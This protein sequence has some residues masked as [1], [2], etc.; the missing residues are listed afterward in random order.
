MD[1]ELNEADT[2]AELDEH[3]HLAFLIGEERY[4]IDVR[5]IVEVLRMPRIQPLP[6]VGEHISGVIN[7]RGQV[8]PVVDLN[9][10]FGIESHTREQRRVV[11]VLEV[12]HETVGVVVDKVQQVRP[13]D[14]D[15]IERDAVGRPRVVA[16]LYGEGDEVAS[17]LDV[18]TL[19]EECRHVT[20]QREEAPR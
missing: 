6:D 4:L 16:G 14:H 5:S 18:A 9:I 1:A 3:A 11:M 19:V 13:L 7:L 10:R 8:I 12:G 15:R 20:V 17:I 2:E